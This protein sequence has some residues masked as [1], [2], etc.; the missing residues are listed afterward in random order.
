MLPKN[1]YSYN[2]AKIF[3]FSQTFWKI[4]KSLQFDSC[5][6]GIISYIVHVAFSLE[7]LGSHKTLSENPW[8]VGNMVVPSSP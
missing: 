3:I 7:L 5:A 2:S 6:D 4:P 1:R 8:H